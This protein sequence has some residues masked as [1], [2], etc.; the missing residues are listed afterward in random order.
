MLFDEPFESK[1]GGG[2]VIVS[3]V[4]GVAE[5]TSHS[6]LSL[7]AGNGQRQFVQDWRASS[8]GDRLTFSTI[9]ATLSTLSLGFR[10]CNNILAWLARLRQGR[11]R[12]GCHARYLPCPRIARILPQS[13]TKLC[14]TIGVMGE[15]YLDH[16]ATTPLLPEAWDAMRSAGFGNPASGHHAGRR[17]RRALEDARERIASLLGAFPD[18]VVFT[19][20]ATEANNLAVFGQAGPLSLCRTRR[21][22]AA[23]V[24]LRAAASL[25]EHPCV[26]E[27]LRELERR[28]VPVEWLAVSPRGV[29]LP[30]TL[31][32]ETRL[33][34]VMLAN[35]E[36]GALQPVSDVAV[37]LPPGAALH[38]DAAQ[39][40]GKIPVDFRTL[41]AATLSA[42]AHKFGGP[43]GVGLLIV[44]R[45]VKLAPQLFGGH[46]QQGRRP[47]TEPA[48]LAAGM[49]AALDHAVTHMSESAARFARFRSRLWER[50][51]AS[52]SPVILNG[53]GVGEPDT[54]PTTLNLS[55][56][57]CRGDLL[58]PALDLAGVACSTGSACSSGSM[59]PSPVL[60]AMGVPDEVLRSAVRF[61]F[62]AGLAGADID[63]GADRIAAVVRRMRESGKMG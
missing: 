32:P 49:A 47:G 48:A 9:V 43:T 4:R 61:S 14:D 22:A 38:C 26:V 41:G 19:S 1:A 59:L 63:D 13:L 58:V 39:A 56:P 31:D 50:L 27:P 40:V 7:P 3:S 30:P 53:V 10:P 34:C 6:P 28:G 46:Q 37:S 25:L 24:S 33:V 57:G 29:L 42:S 5:Q 45:G 16:N 54:L 23:A 2:L 18:E 62:G 35:H 52:A 15:I 21:S 36:T 60:K 44:R 55:F 11:V 17:A 20:G 8:T 51:S 12:S